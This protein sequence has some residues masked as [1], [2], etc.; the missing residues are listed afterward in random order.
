MHEDIF[1]NDTLSAYI[2]LCTST[3]REKNISGLCHSV[4]WWLC[5]AH[6][7]L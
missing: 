3:L 2:G 4:L 5:N 6:A 7:G 1:F